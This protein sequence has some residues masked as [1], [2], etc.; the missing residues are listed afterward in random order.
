MRK[1]LSARQAHIVPNVLRVWTVRVKTDPTDQDITQLKK[2]TVV[3]VLVAFDI[4]M[5][6]TLGDYPRLLKK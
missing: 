1:Q 4:L 2:M 6:T 3:R 5:V